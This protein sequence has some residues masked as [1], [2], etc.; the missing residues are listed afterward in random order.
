[1]ERV[2]TDRNRI[3]GGG[4]TAGIDA[5]LAIVTAVAGELVAA[6]IA[7]QLEYDPQ[8]QRGGH[9]R[10]ADPDL[11]ATTRARLAERHA[12]RKARLRRSD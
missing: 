7:L 6:Q 4:V 5:A 12:I 11:V 2:V 8:L 1:V 3:T 9:P 10:T